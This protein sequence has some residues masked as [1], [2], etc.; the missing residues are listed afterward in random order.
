MTSAIG[1]TRILGSAVV[2]G[3]LLLAAGSPAVAAECKGMER[4][5]CERQDSC[6]WVSSYTRSDGVTV[7]GHCRSKGKR[8]TSSSTSSSSSSSSSN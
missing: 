6:S 5:S 8:S 1:L 3:A 4:A 7:S 2:S